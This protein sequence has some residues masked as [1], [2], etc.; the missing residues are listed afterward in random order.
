MPYGAKKLLA[1][2]P[3]G[4]DSKSIVMAEAGEIIAQAMAQ[5][6]NRTKKLVVFISDPQKRA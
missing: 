5:P 3:A 6:A 4:M 1:T 2:L